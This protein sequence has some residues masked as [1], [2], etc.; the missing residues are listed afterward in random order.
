MSMLPSTVLNKIFSFFDPNETESI[1]I[2]NLISKTWNQAEKEFWKNIFKVNKLPEPNDPK[3]LFSLKE[4]WCTIIKDKGLLIKYSKC[5]KNLWST[6]FD[7]SDWTKEEKEWKLITLNELIR[8]LFV[9]D[10][11]LVEPFL[12]TFPAF[13]NDYVVLMKI[14]EIFNS[15]SEA[16]HKE[17]QLFVVSLIK[18]WVHLNVFTSHLS[19]KLSRFKEF[20]TDKNFLKFF[21]ETQK[22]KLTRNENNF[23]IPSIN[24]SMKKVYHK[25]LSD[26]SDI[27]VQDFTEQFTL[28]SFDSYALIT[29]ED[30]LRFPSGGNSLSHVF[31]LSEQ[32]ERVS[33]WICFEI[34]KE[35]KLAAR[36]KKLKFFIECAYQ[37]YKTHNYSDA[38]AFFSGITN[39]YITSLNSTFTLEKKLQ[40]MILE[41]ESI[42]VSE[43][44]FEKYKSH[45]SEIPIETPCLP[46][47]GIVTNDLML[48]LDGAVNTDYLID[49]GMKKEEYSIVKKYLQYQTQTYK[50]TR[51][52]MIQA[53]I[54]RSLYNP[55]FPTDKEMF[56]L[57]KDR[58]AAESDTKRKSS[59][60][61]IDMLIF[62]SKSNPK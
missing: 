57:A 31:K 45:L 51:I 44:K 23:V 16:N 10:L 24:V 2:A 34:L 22:K 25:T 53:F 19:K 29:R 15:E 49:W 26:V 38:F 40:N 13:T 58:K 43:S 17:L 56:Q 4:I 39:S 28:R 20:T 12:F 27:D 7:K 61:L 55:S 30:V 11:N 50:F 32:T 48:N 59:S 36:Q 52:S 6:K 35:F 14:F 37:F 1:H 42:F 33:T 3:C 46:Y 54:S 41:M 47:L 5:Y 21:D 18:K 8:N 60:S 9:S 62:S